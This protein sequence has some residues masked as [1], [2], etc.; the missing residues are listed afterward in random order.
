[1]RLTRAAEYAIRCMVYLAKQGKGV[2][3]SR[4][5]I[6]ERAEIPG[7]FLA[8]IAQDLAKAGFL[9]IRQGAKGGFVLLKNPIEISLLEVVETMIGE[10]YLND[11]IA[12]PASCKV[13]YSCAVH[14]VWLEARDQL[15]AT[16]AR[17][18]FEQL[19]REE[20]CIAP[21]SKPLPSVDELTPDTSQPPS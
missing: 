10:I 18:S 19:V 9:E 2:L 6:A 4:Q 15:R 5:E 1:M 21:C 12:R 17:V 13:S 7:H 16:L 20:S 3:T 14:R 11:C 8:K